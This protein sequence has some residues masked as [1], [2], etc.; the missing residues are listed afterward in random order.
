MAVDE[1]QWLGGRQQNGPPTQNTSSYNCKWLVSDAASLRQ[2]AGGRL[3]LMGAGVMPTIHYDE[4]HRRLPHPI[5]HE[6]DLG[7]HTSCCLTS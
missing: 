2:A 6:Q 3:T 7:L 5:S 4:V 1:G